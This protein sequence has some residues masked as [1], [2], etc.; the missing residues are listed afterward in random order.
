MVRKTSFL[1]LALAFAAV[2]VLTRAETARAEGPVGP[3]RPPSLVAPL[4]HGETLDLPALDERVP[5][6]ET[7]LGYPLGARFTGW[8]RIVAYLEALD[9]ASAK[10]KMWEYGHSYEG[11]PLKLAAISS[12]ENIE[13]LDEIRANLQRL[14][15]PAGL[16]GSERER[17]LRHTPAVVWLAYGVHGNE[18]SSAE[19]AMGTAYV[20]AAAQGEMAQMLEN[21]VVLVDPLQNPDGRERYVNAYRQRRGDDA[22]PRRASAEHFEPWPGGRQNHYVIDLNRDWAWASQQETRQRIAAYRSWEPQVY[23]DF[24]E[25]GTDSSYFFPP[26]AEPINP[27]IDRRILGWLDKFGRANAAA[28]D[29][30]GWIYFKEENYDLF[31]PGYGDSYPSL[32]GAVGMTYEMAGGG[33]AG[34]AMAL[35]DGTVLTLADRIAR[36]LTTSLATVRTAAKNGHKLLEDFTAGRAKAGGETPRTFLWPAD[37]QEARAL[38]D[39]LTLHGVRVRQ[40]GQAVETPVKALS[41]GAGEAQPR[42]FAAGTYAVS[43]AQPLGNLVAALME[44]ESPMNKGFLDRQRQRLEQN[45]DA[46]FYDITAWS[47]PL[48]YNVRTWIAQG[49]VTGGSGGNGGNAKAALETAAGGIR[50]E[51][52]LGWL[53]PPQG[54][55]SYRLSAA[56]QKRQ[57][58]YRVA[59]AAFSGDGASYPA[60]TL[61]IPRR[62]NPDTLRDVLQALL[63]EDRLTAQ[64]V[65]SSWDFKGSLGS[66]D[67]AAVRPARVG[68]I[69]GDGVD[70]T[71]FGFLWHLLD[72]QIGVDYDRL[73]LGQIRQ[74]PLSDF[75]VLVFPSGAYDDRVGDK[76]KE[77]LDAWVKAGGVLVAIGDAVSWLQDKELTTIKRWTPPK[78]TDSEDS[79]ETE[80]PEVA[81]TPLE[82]QLASKPIFTPGAVIAT[83]MQAQ[84]ELTLGLTSSPSVLYEGTLVLKATNDPR[85]DVLTALDDHPIV[86]GFAWPEAER[87]L[88]GSLLVGTE[89][90][91][92]GS[93]VLFAEDPAY[94]LFWRA[95]TPI[96]LNALLYGPSTGLGRRF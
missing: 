87:R 52:D 80:D 72:R 60:G 36:H 7:V 35:Q 69:S 53:V 2:L 25:M 5:R 59:L 68:L 58:R 51:G 92:R 73:D 86:A 83:R 38:A 31:Y 65:A 19:A 79:K 32:R 10:V 34:T 12:P 95:T 30:Q 90:R 18:A 62:A 46:E 81:E 3:V 41:R 9:A 42:K 14:A 77:S 39:L 55:A 48:A 61:F 8:D 50:G 93:V 82:K 75:D 44:L 20:L 21:L 54:I 85:Q 96:L 49:D 67:M 40:L 28:F 16:T 1:T 29:H 70:S 89:A 47:L 22:N 27:L 94:R 33:R 66:H 74:I 84:H 13:R 88:A 17:L 64:A 45:L 6:P 76:V 71:S 91:G 56:L 24:H 63:Q 57:V 78:K 15:D 37:Q 4:S 23:V 43:T 11:R 26:A